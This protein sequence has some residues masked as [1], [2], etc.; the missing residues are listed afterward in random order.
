[1]TTILCYIALLILPLCSFLLGMKRRSGC[2][3]MHAKLGYTSELAL[4]SPHAWARA[5]RA[6]SLRYMIVSVLLADYDEPDE[7]DRTVEAKK[8]AG[9]DGAQ[10]E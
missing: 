2:K 8:T 3:E 7:F 10:D 1:M 4:T 5:Q 6:S 9:R